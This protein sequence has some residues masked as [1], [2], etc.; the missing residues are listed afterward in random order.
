MKESQTQLLDA[1]EVKRS[2]VK[3]SIDTLLEAHGALNRGIAVAKQT[4]SLTPEDVAALSASVR[5]LQ[6]DLFVA[7][8]M[9]K[10]VYTWAVHPAALQIDAVRNDA[11]KTKTTDDFEFD[12]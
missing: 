9:M 6:T 11:R 1:M 10:K 12:A 3:A 5:E 8:V 2:Q 4:R 7:K